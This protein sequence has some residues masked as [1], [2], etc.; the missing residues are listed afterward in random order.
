MGYELKIQNLNYHVNDKQIL[1]DINVSLNSGQFAA[2]LGENGSGKSTLLDL[3]M[4]F[5]IPKAGK[6]LIDNKE[7]HHDD[8]TLKA[9]TIYLSEKMEVPVYW[10]IG[11]F[12]DFHKHFYKQYSDELEK[13]YMDEYKI[14]RSTSFRELSAGENKRAQIVAALS[15]NPQLILVDEITAVLDIVGRQRFMGHLSALAKK[16]CTVVMA[17]NI[18]ENIEQYT[19]HL[20]L[21]NKGQLSYFGEVKAFMHQQKSTHFIDQIASILEAA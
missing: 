12:L 16:G 19:S 2:L 11:D 5:R 6:V 10:K 13:Q 8:L 20:I 7:P 15:S 21:L 17:T 9:N 4:G 14:K 1:K 3:L 18:L